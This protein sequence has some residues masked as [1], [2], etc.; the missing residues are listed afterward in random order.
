[1]RVLLQWGT[2]IHTPKDNLFKIS[3]ATLETDLSLYHTTQMQGPFM[4]LCMCE[5]GGK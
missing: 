5:P 4:W 2:E 1:M 3:V